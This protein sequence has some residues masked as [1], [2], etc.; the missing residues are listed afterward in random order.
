MPRRW[1]NLIEIATQGPPK[2]TTGIFLS[3]LSIFLT[4][5]WVLKSTQRLL[6]EIWPNS[7]NEP[8]KYCSEAVFV[9]VKSSANM[10]KFLEN[11]QN[12]NWS[13]LNGYADPQQCYSSFVNKYTEIYDNCFPFKK[14][15]LSERCLNKPWISLGLLKSIKKKNKLYKQYLSNPS[16]HSEV[17]YKRYKNKLNHSLRVAKT[18]LLWQEIRG[19]QI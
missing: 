18:S 19:I 6:T 9:R 16:N 13:H 2:V 12:V 4:L 1:S 15:K 10:N 7:D 17:H 11:L 3:I 8:V 5:L 14:I